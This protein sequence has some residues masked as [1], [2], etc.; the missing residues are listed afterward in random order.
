MCHWTSSSTHGECIIFF[1]EQGWVLSHLFLTYSPPQVLHRWHPSCVSFLK[2]III[3][4]NQAKT[5]KTQQTCGH[6][7]VFGSKCKVHMP[8]SPEAFFRHG[9]LLTCM[10]SG[11][12]N[13]IKVAQVSWVWALAAAVARMCMILIRTASLKKKTK[14]NSNLTH[15]IRSTLI[16]QTKKIII[17]WEHSEVTA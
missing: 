9:C 6:N 5:W 3:S 16:K 12:E 14:Q 2:L 10:A 7:Q 13:L 11:E 15:N 4:A 17:I 1:V 8:N